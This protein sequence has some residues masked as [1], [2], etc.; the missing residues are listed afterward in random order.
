ME[1]SNSQVAGSAPEQEAS[2]PAQVSNQRE[3]DSV[4][5]KTFAT[6]LGQVKKTKAYNEELVQKVQTYESERKNIEE[7][8]L[9]EQGEYKK[10]LEMRNAE[11]ESLN[12][13]V[14]DEAQAKNIANKTLIDAQKLQAVYEELPGRLDKPEFNTFIDLN[15]VAYNPDT[16]DVDMESAKMVANKFMDRYGKLVDTGKPRGLPGTASSTTTPLP[17]TFKELPLN[18]MRANLPE[19]VRQAKQEL[20]L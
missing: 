5:Y 6:L 1:N 20:G 2:S 10:L 16:G 3:N 15:S 18:G 13:K 19:A 11:I 7:V 12:R 17:Q 9:A 14:E 8:K 4:D